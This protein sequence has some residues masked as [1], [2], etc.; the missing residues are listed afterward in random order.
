MIFDRQ[1]DASEN[2]NKVH[3]PYLSRERDKL[4]AQIKIRKSQL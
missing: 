1:L 3:C 2:E 4:E